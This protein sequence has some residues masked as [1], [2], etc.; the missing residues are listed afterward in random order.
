ES[1]LFGHEKGAFT[2]AKKRREGY[3]EQADGGTIFLDELGEMPLATQVK[4]LR[5]L[6]QQEF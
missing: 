5:V 2:D 6:E 3:F 1:E 4:L